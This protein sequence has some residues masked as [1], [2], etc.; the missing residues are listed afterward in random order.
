MLDIKKWFAKWNMVSYLEREEVDWKEVEKSF[1]V[2]L[3]EKWA[4]STKKSKFE[5]YCQVIRP[6]TKR[7]FSEMEG[8]AQAYLTIPLTKLQRSNLGRIRM[9]SHSLELEKGAWAG[10]PKEERICNVCKDGNAIEDEA[11]LLLRC[12]AYSHLRD[13]FGS[14]RQYQDNIGKFLTESPQKALGIYVTKVLSFRENL[15]SQR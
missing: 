7:E 6:Y 15:I 9:R 3:W 2:S 12:P 14:L 4:S 8:A 1:K 13:Q 5:Y 10:T 11:H